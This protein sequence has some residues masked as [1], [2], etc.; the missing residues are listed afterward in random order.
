M[1]HP[2]L[3]FLLI[4]TG[5]ALGAIVR[6]WLSILIG[7]HLG[8]GF[9]LGTLA[10]N[11]SGAAALGLLAGWLVSPGTDGADTL[12]WLAAATGVL[13]SYTTVSSFSLQT[14]VMAQGGRTGHA[15][16]YVALSALACIAAAGAGMAAFA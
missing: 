14:L 5:G 11:V 10:V 15:F 3:S 6:H 2:I 13:G 12:I 4:A 8:E 9:P 7:R 16:A 1:A